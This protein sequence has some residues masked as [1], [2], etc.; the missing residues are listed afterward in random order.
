[1]LSNLEKL[2]EQNDVHNK[3]DNWILLSGK[4]LKGSMK[5]NL[6]TRNN[7]YTANK[8]GIPILFE[9]ILLILKYFFNDFSEK[10]KILLKVNCSWVFS[11]IFV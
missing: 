8:I 2:V 1:M 10:K 11:I 7:L 5:L 9:I 4:F 6:E 3:M